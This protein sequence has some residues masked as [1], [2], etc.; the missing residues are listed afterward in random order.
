VPPDVRKGYAF[1][2]GFLLNLVGLRPD[3]GAAEDQIQ[4]TPES[5]RLSAHRAAEP[6]DRSILKLIDCSVRFADEEAQES[7]RGG[8][9][10][11]RREVS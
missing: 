11:L 8:G 3:W 6:R 1:P 10:D 4:V 2:E 9:F 7:D 5:R